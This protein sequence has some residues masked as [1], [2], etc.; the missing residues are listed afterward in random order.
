MD[1]KECMVLVEG[2]DKTEEIEKVVDVDNR[3]TNVFYKSRKEPYRYSSNKVEVLNEP[4]F[5]DINGKIVYKDDSFIPILD[6]QYVLDFG[7]KVRICDYKGKYCTVDKASFS[8]VDG[9]QSN[10]GIQDILTYLKEVTKY[11]SKEKDGNSFLRD[12]MEQLSCIHPESVL[13]QYLCKQPPKKRQVNINE[14]IF[15]FRFNLSQKLALENALTNSISVIQ[16]PPGTGK[17]QTIL[18]IIANLVSMQKKSVAVVSNN[19]EAVKNVKEKLERQGYGFLTA[20]LGKADNQQAFFEQMPLA[21]VEEW[22]CKESKEQLFQMIQI[23]NA[24]LNDLLEKDRKRVQLKQQLREWKIE[25]EHF[26]QYF[27][28]QKV[29]EITKLPLFLNTPEDI[30]SLLAEIT[31]AKKYK[32][33]NT[34][35]FKLKMLLKYGMYRFK[36]LDDITFTLSLEKRLYKAQVELL[37]QSISSKEKELEEGNF[38]DMIQ[39]HQKQSELLFRK[40]LYES[41]NNIQEP[42]FTIRDFKKRFNEFTKAYPIILSTTHAIRRSIPKGYLLDYLIIDESS[43]VDLVT[44]VLALSCCRNVIIVGDTKQLPQ[45]VNKTLEETIPI[46][47]P[48][49]EYNYFN[50]SLLSSILEVYREKIPC[51]TLREHYRCHPQIIQFCNQK[52][53]NG[54]LIAYTNENICSDPL[55]LYKTAEGNHMRRITKGSGKGVY[56]QRE[57]DVIVNDVLKNPKISEIKNNVG[58]VTPYRKQANKAKELFSDDIECDTVHKYQGREKDIMIMSTVLDNTRDG[59]RGIDFV[60]DPNMINVAVSRAI[61]QF[62]LV[63]DKELFFHKG[64][65]IV[66]LIRY[67]QYNTISENIIQSQI[68][69]IFDLLYRQYSSK[70]IALKE[71]MD[72]QEEFQSEEAFRVLLEEILAQSEY[73]CYE[74]VREL[75]ICNILCSTE[76]LTKEEERLYY[77]GSLDFVI[78]RKQDKTCVLVIEVDGFAFHENNPEQLENDRLKDS[79]LAKYNIPI[80]RLASNG[81]MEREKVESMLQA[82]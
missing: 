76:K 13:A 66:D 35:L 10:G 65:H 73:S 45:I 43:Q 26:K 59:N 48:S 3:I 44:G 24:K 75:K 33:A 49:D 55:I 67:I 78:F 17:T 16:G 23:S 2:I 31:M 46:K 82:Q 14:V 32:K 68:V 52:Y 28:K 25:Q 29:E 60:D 58:M 72:S 41:H 20:L 54:Q 69:S 77:Y 36:Q 30:S 18:N 47:S 1:M 9:I 70:L 19:N 27:E 5:V 80:I 53:Y 11:R 22:N 79:I 56:N 38:E 81:S 71:K 51:T 40:C 7:K 42:N 50:H 37:E 64:E 8:I 12:E 57:L 15:P 39:N 63:T 61:K 21:N 62:V 6:P 4:V 74:Y 34:L